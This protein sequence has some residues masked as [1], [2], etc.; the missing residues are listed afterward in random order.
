MIVPGREG[1]LRMGCVGGGLKCREVGLIGCFGH[2]IGAVEENR[3]IRALMK[4]NNILPPGI[5]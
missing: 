3:N 5:I 1:W 2:Y 4:K